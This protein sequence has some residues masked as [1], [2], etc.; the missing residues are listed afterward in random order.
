MA[1]GLGRD[2]D[3]VV[4]IVPVVS[5]LWFAFRHM[6]GGQGRDAGSKRR[7]MGSKGGGRGE[8]TRQ[9]AVD[10]PRESWCECGMKQM[11]TRKHGYEIMMTHNIVTQSQKMVNCRRNNK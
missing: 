7:S 6:G 5:I 3:L 4:N 11:K 1:R 10:T 2:G 9:Q 8:A